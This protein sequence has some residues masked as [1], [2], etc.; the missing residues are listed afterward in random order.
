[1]IWVDGMALIFRDV[2]ESVKQYARALRDD[3]GWRFYSVKQQ[4]GRCYY[5]SRVITIPIHAIN[6]PHNSY[7]IWYVSHEIA[8]AYTPGAKHGDAFMAKLIEICPNDC[9]KHELGYKPRNA[10]RAGI[11]KNGVFK[12]IDF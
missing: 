4:R 9:I 5:G 11:T 7:K 12:L 6:H 2:P 3:K 10:E 1:M 8:H